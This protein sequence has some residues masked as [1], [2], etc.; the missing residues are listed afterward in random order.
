MLQERAPIHHGVV[1]Q[2]VGLIE[3]VESGSGMDA[4]FDPPRYLAGRKTR[5]AGTIWYAGTIVHDT[6]HAKLLHDYLATSED[7]TSVPPEVWTGR[8]AVALC[9]A[10]QHNAL[11]EIGASQQILDYVKKSIDREYWDVPFDQRWW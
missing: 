5:D 10:A 8:D 11:S 3:C 2:Y 9:L 1:T 6:C 7:T 4:W